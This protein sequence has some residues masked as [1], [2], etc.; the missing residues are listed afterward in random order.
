M[1]LCGLIGLAHDK[2]HQQ[3]SFIS[4]IKLNNSYRSMKFVFNFEVRHPRCVGSITKEFYVLH[5]QS[6]TTIFHLVIQQ[7]YN[8]MFRPYMLAI[9]R[10]LFILQG[11]D[12][13]CVGYFLGYWRER[14][15]VVSIV[16]T[17][18]QGYDCAKD[19][20]QIVSL[21]ILVSI[22]LKRACYD[23]RVRKYSSN[24]IIVSLLLIILFIT[25][26]QHKN[27]NLL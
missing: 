20:L 18:T 16:G 24:N 3:F 9:L 2:A 12:T 8:Y 22:Y 6:N 26:I 14:D 19:V 10:L 7:E 15:L 11:S 21:V 25:Y 13:R 1:L 23:V 4:R 27:N 17:M 5:I